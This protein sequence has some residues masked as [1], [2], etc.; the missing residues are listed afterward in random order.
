MT[1]PTIFDRPMTPAERMRRHRARGQR[2][3]PRNV[4]EAV[5][6][7][8]QDYALAYKWFNLAA[9]QNNQDAEKYRDS[10][11]Q[12]MTPAQIAEA[13]KLAREWK[14]TRQPPE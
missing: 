13:Q 14:P 5:A 4:K 11:A 7:V 12:R 9:A 6:C 3:A 2:P 10:I 1:R 8:P